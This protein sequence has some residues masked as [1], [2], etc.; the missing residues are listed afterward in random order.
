[1]LFGVHRGYSSDSLSAVS[2]TVLV[3]TNFIP[4]LHKSV[5]IN[6]SARKLTLSATD[7]TTRSVVQ[8][9]SLKYQLQSFSNKDIID[10]G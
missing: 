9:L 3:A 6:I 1:M 8:R 2:N 10:Q 5:G 7:R 4:H